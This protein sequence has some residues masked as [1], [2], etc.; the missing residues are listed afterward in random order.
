MPNE[1]ICAGQDSRAY[2]LCFD[3]CRQ[4]T[5]GPCFPL[6][7]IRCQTHRRGFTL[8]PPGHVPYGR[9]AVAPVAPDGS[10]LAK[11]A[12]QNAERFRGTLFDGAL[13]AADG[14][15]WHREHA[16]PTDC[17]W[18]S[19]LRGL[20]VATRLVGV[21]AENDDGAREQLAELL[22]VDT[23]LLRE[24]AQQLRHGAGYRK[25]GQAVRAVLDALPRS[26]LLP[27]RLLECGYQIG[28]WGAPYRW[29]ADTAV[30]VRMPFRAAGTPRA[31]PPP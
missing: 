8:Y 16:G 10:P 23:L 26:A 22:D 24:Q 11:Q 3:H 9:R 5:T 25:R 27:D 7:V 15:A 12:R 13:D 20:E 2:R 30:L 21:A 19:Q 29:L 17:W 28:Q 1:G 4:R 6:T 31:R 14:R 18:N